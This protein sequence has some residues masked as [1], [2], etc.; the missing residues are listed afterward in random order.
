MYFSATVTR[1][2]PSPPLTGRSSDQEQEKLGATFPRIPQACLRSLSRDEN[3]EV[4]SNGKTGELGNHTKACEGRGGFTG[5]QDSSINSCD[6]SSGDR[7][8]VGKC[9]QLGN[10]SSKDKGEGSRPGNQSKRQKTESK[11]SEASAS[12]GKSSE[13]GKQ[14]KKV[15][16]RAS[17][18]SGNSGKNSEIGNQTTPIEQRKDHSSRHQAEESGMKRVTEEE[19]KATGG[20]IPVPERTG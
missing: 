5:N 16:A 18:G 14:A 9:S 20:V 4:K 17:D 19:E 8:S 7:A 12:T 6:N 13:I 11:C 3:T 1:S 15:N 2:S 10:Q